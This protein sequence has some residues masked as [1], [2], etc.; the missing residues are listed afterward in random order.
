MLAAVGHP[1]A[2]N[3]DRELAR[4]ARERG[5]AGG[6]VPPGGPAAGAGAHARA[7][8]RRDRGQR[9]RGGRPGGGCV[10]VV[11]ADRSGYSSRTFLAAMEASATKT[12]RMSS[13]FMPTG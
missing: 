9:G 7:E 6:A 4:A 5:L 1:V 3:P 12:M 11:A 13:F 2:V 8:A 10:V